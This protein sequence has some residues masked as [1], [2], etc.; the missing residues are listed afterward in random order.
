MKFPNLA[1]KS[2]HIGS[3]PYTDIKAALEVSFSFDIPAWPQLS[4]FKE[5]GMLWQFIGDFPGFSLSEEKVYSNHPSFEEDMLKIYE[6]YVEVLEKRDKTLLFSFLKK[7]FSKAFFPFL[8]K[9][10][11][12]S[13]SLLKGQ[14]TGPFTLGI[15]LKNEEGS[16][17][18]FREDLRDLLVK[19]ITLKALSQ[20][21]YLKEVASEVIIFL[22][23]P[24]LS[25]FGSS[26]YVSLSKDLVAESL[27]EIILTLKSFNIIT[28]I[29][30]CA[31]T[32]WDLLLETEV[33]ILSLDSFTYF[34]R[35]ALYGEKIC[36]F[37]E[38]GGYIAWGAIPTDNHILKGID[39]KEVLHSFL[40]GLKS[41]AEKTSFKEED[42]LARSLLTPACGLGSLS[43]DL[44]PKVVSLINS[45]KKAF[46][47]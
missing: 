12:M 39:E 30:V 1:L 38:K 32:S 43:E 42:L 36:E 18:I 26:A 8:E 2:T 47:K 37:L 10:K 31:N 21:L 13:S 29:H 28:G 45:I 27:K 16:P 19:F 14:I 34:E 22:D 9:A 5:E 33:D 20:A 46:G 6:R 17:I 41:L 40:E 3:L 11:E 23:E 24:G 35:F 25:G 4:K 44:V 15:S 7:D